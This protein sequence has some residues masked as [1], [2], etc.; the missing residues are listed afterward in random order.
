MRNDT[1]ETQQVERVTDCSF[2]LVAPS[3][4]QLLI[5]FN[6]ANCDLWDSECSIVAFDG[7]SK[8]SQNDLEPLV[9]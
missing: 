6:S 8:Q 5:R 3:E 7:D 1:N 2:H 4:S 9:S